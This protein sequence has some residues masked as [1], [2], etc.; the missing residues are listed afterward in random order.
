MA[1]GIVALV[2]RCKVLG[3]QLDTTDEAAAFLWADE[4]E[5]AQQAQDV[6]AVRVLDGPGTMAADRSSSRWDQSSKAQYPE[7]GLVIRARP[8]QGGRL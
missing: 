6:Y 7:N 5:I 2:L 3:G 8:C 1:R 4:R